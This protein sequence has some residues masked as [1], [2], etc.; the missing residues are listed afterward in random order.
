MPPRRRSKLAPRIVIGQCGHKCE[1]EPDLTKGNDTYVI[2][3]ICDD[4]VPVQKKPEQL[5]ILDA[6]DTPEY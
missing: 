2:C 4:W 1:K 6:L 3:D 5:S